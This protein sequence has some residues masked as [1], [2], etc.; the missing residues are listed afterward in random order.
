M[1]E[2]L[3]ESTETSGKDNDINSVSCEVER[4]LAEPLLDFTVGNPFKW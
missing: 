1:S 3:P 2:I 4:Y